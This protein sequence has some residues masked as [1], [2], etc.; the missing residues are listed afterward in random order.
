MPEQELMTEDDIKM[1]LDGCLKIRAHKVPSGMVG[2]LYNIDGIIQAAEAIF[3]HL[4]R[5]A[6]LF[7]GYV[8]PQKKE[9]QNGSEKKRSS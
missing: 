9:K 4:E 5:R 6:K 3:Y 8:K 1:H 2:K 7:E